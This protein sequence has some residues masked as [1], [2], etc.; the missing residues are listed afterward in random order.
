MASTP[1]YILIA[2]QYCLQITV[3]ISAIYY[4]I[5]SYYLHILCVYIEALELHSQS[6]RSCNSTFCKAYI[7]ASSLIVLSLIVSSLIASSLI[8][9]SS[10]ILSVIV[11]LPLAPASAC[12]P[13]PT[14]LGF[15]TLTRFIHISAKAVAIVGNNKLYGAKYAFAFSAHKRGCKHIEGEAGEI[16]LRVIA[17]VPVP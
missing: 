12:Y 13:F 1:L 8:T 5:T 2:D 11:V 17:V 10:I 6:S 15:K 14:V 7:I 9:S 16:W 3:P 4:P